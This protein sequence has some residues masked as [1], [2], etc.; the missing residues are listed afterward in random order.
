MF[1]EL[2]V[3]FFQLFTACLCE[4]RVLGR[5]AVSFVTQKLSLMGVVTRVAKEQARLA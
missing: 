1:S 4:L 5:L 2:K 3:S